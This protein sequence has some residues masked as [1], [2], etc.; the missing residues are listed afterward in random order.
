MRQKRFLSWIMVF[1]LLVGMF[2]F[3]AYAEGNTATIRQDTPNQQETMNI[4]LVIPKKTPAATDL[5]YAAPSDLTYSGSDKA[6]TVAAASGATGMG[7]ITVKYYSDAARTTEATPKNVGTYYVGATVAEGDQYAAST[8][9][10]YGDG[11]TFE[12]TKSTPSAP[13]APT[14]ASV[15]KNSITLNAV[16]GCEYSK[17]GAKWQDGT[18]FAGL[19]PGTEYTFYQR[20]KATANTNASPASQG[21]TFST[22]ADTYAMTVT[23]VIK[24]EQ[25]ITAP[26]VAATYGDTGKSVSARTDGDG[27][28]GYAVKSG[29]AVTV[30][31]TTGALTIVKAGTATITVTAAETDTCKQ[32]TKDVTVTVAKAASSVTKAPEATNPAYTGKAQALVTAGTAEG[33]E[34]QYSLDGSNF[35][36]EIPT[37]TYAKAYTVWYK[38]VGDANHLDSDPACVE[39]TVAAKPDPAKPSYAATSGAGSTWTRGSKDGLAITFKR[40]VEGEDKDATF[41][42][43]VSASVDGR[44]LAKDKDYAAAEGSVV[45]TLA[46]AYL[47][48]LSTGKHELTATFDDGSSTAEFTVADEGKPGPAP[49]PEPTPAMTYAVTFD[50]NGGTGTMDKL[51]V[52]AGKSVAL[53]ANAF[54]RDGYAFSG[55]NTAKDGSGTAYADKATVT[56]TADLTLY[57]QWRKAA[58]SPQQQTGR[59]SQATTSKTSTAKSSLPKTGDPAAPV[60]ALATAVAGAG[61]VLAGRRRRR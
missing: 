58:S 10:L 7:D 16:D 60:A 40:T 52:E 42:H 45:V 28:L 4:T 35:S 32:A 13:A 38:V 1:T 46:P 55:W 27:A 9:V 36:K 37:G 18:E 8:A 23:L 26:D 22:E 2:R 53:T 54:K 14:M 24:P 21:A 57:A 39:A 15:T 56:P 61:A 20:V 11:W 17:D 19:M 29:D 49:Q 43:F 59:T 51:A 44:E 6:A 34:M 48:T 5:T 12:I 30:N 47:E 33:G 41:A 31:A 3:P 25:T 50:A